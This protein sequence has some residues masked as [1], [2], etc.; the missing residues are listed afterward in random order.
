MDFLKG[1]N[2]KLQYWKREQPE[3]K[4]SSCWNHRSHETQISQIQTLTETLNWTNTINFWTQS[5]PWKIKYNETQK[6]GEIGHGR[7]RH[8]G[9]SEDSVANNTRKE[10]AAPE[11]TTKKTRWHFSGGNLYSSRIINYTQRTAT[12]LLMLLLS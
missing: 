1:E 5:N 12:W 11:R 9:N 3:P 10:I 7:Q 8:P 2:K 6:F 4:I